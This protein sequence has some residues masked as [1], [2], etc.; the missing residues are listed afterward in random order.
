MKKVIVTLGIALIGAASQASTVIQFTTGEG[1]SN[2]VLN[3]QNSWNA[4]TAW[5]VTDAAALG[6]VKTTSNGAGAT[7][8][9]PITL[10]TGQSYS[11]SANFEFNGTYT[12]GGQGASDQNVFGLGIS[13]GISLYGGPDTAEATLVVRSNT[14]AAGTSAYTILNNFGP[15]AD[16][17]TVNGF[18]AGDV[19]QLDYT[20]T[21]GSDAGTSFFS[22][23]LTNLT[24]STSTALGTFT[25]L[26]AGVY[27]AL[28]GTGAYA[29]FRTSFD[30]T[31]TGVNGAQVNSFSFA[32][33]PEPSTMG[34]L[35]FALGG[36][37]SRRRR[38]ASSLKF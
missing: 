25:G 3:G 37:M 8:G 20:L 15:F 35:A 24:D 21:L 38:R 29:Y 36:L 28:T 18:N 11:L 17:T 13:S 14:N 23:Q 19:F 33:V 1:Y 4:N 32:A 2:G 10:T 16:M 26:D 31:A 9:I 34:L 30:M 6:N 5:S 22:T 27:T 7:L 12:A